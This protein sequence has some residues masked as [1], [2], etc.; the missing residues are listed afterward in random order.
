MTD[1]PIPQTDPRAGYLEHKAEIDAAIAAVLRSGQYILGPAVEEFERAFARWLGVGHAVGTGSGT[2]ALELALRA[3]DVGPGDLVFTVSHTAVATVAAIER[4]GAV[5]VLIDIEAGGF[6]MDPAQLELALQNPPPGRAAAVLPVHLYGEAADLAPIVQLTR[7]HGLRLIEDCAQSHGARYQG[8]MT[9]SFGDIACFSFYPTKN[10]GALG[11]AGM[12]ATNDV[13]LAVALREVREYGWRDRYVSARL[14]INT[15]LDPLQAAIVGAKLLHLDADNTSRQAIAEHYDRELAELPLERPRRRPHSSHVFHQYV[16]RCRERDALREHLRR[17][18]IGTGI[19]YPLPV[20]LQPAYSGRLAEF[21]A[22]LP[23]T[24]E[25]VLGILS[26]PMFPQ[27]GGA[28]TRRV[29]AEIRR[30]FE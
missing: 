8:R 10:L 1:A 21:P 2:D 20:H 11:D 25:A 3:C 16:I 4:A 17:A 23:A 19:H 24:T 30:F 6:T 28:A 29:T 5:P 9:G 15:R 26:L 13:G 12:T 22:G 14:G 27:L 18:K 7:R